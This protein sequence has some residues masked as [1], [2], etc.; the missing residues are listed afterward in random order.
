MPQKN[1]HYQI[2][3]MQ[4]VILKVLDCLFCLSADLVKSLHFLH[5]PSELKD[6]IAGL[7]CVSSALYWQLS[8]ITG[9]P[10]YS[11]DSLKFWFNSTAYD[12]SKFCCMAS[13]GFVLN[14]WNTTT[15]TNKTAATTALPCCVKTLI[16]QLK[17][18]GVGKSVS[19]KHK[20][21]F[22]LL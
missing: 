4:K 7:T 14:S 22:K 20:T 15:K 17:D 8:R 2:Y 5:N 12:S 11:W 6:D 16:S 21:Q 19:A 9:A 10:I 3:Y 13:G 1:D 18:K